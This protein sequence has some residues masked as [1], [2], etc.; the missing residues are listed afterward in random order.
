MEGQRFA[1]LGKK[2]SPARTE[3]MY[4]AA[5]K[6]VEK[7][8]ALDA[9]AK[10]R[11]TWQGGAHTGMALF[12]T[13][14]ASGGGVHHAEHRSKDGPAPI[15]ETKKRRVRGGAPSVA[16]KGTASSKAH[17]A[18]A[19]AAA[20]SVASKQASSSSSS[21]K[22]KKKTPHAA[23]ALAAAADEAVEE[24]AAAETVA[25]AEAVEV[26]LG[27]EGPPSEGD[28]G[29]PSEGDDGAEA[30]ESLPAAAAAP[31]LPAAPAAV[32]TPPTPPAAAAPEEGEM[33]SV[34]RR[35]AQARAL[36]AAKQ[37]EAEVDDE[38]VDGEAY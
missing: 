38:E 26:E 28:E 21:K 9:K 33:S 27:D 13:R 10:Y 3:A 22:K 7:R 25:A 1:A 34:Q 31:A 17:A 32:A 8:N 37:A 16:S 30:D 29:P 5:L 35:L 6:Q 24:V 36:V 2:M 18:V 15:E 19:A 14:G 12:P 20:S 4:A 11:D 23:A